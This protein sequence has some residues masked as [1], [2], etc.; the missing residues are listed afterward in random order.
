MSK[1]FCAIRVGV[2]VAALCAFSYTPWA[3]AQDC[4]LV[5]RGEIPLTR[6]SD[7]HLLLSVALNGKPVQ[8]A[9]DFERPFTTISRAKVNEL[10][11]PVTNQAGGEF[12]LGEDALG[13]VAMLGSV[14]LGAASVDRLEAVVDDG[15]KAYNGIILG[16]NMLQYFLPE[17]DLAHDV[18]RLF[19]K[20]H[21]PDKVVYWAPDYL[22]FKYDDHIGRMLLDAKVDGRDVHAML[23]PERVQSTISYDVADASGISHD[24]GGALQT[25]EFG[26]ITLRHAA[27]Q[28]A[29]LRYA[30]G[31]SGPDAHIQARA[32]LTPTDIKIGADVLK[33]L[34]F[35]IDFEAKTVYFTVG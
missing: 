27:V 14:R 28:V 12:R 30:R 34:R 17:F 2:I 10:D 13:D 33:H 23:A 9:L 32:L 31:P 3:Q 16:Y 5:S 15:R 29:D 26:G 7:G 22:T 20:R 25:L 19:D 18:I 35:I 24:T 6:S 21:C 8:M 1:F 11:A 4:K